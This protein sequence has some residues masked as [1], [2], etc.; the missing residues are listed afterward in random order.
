M[1][2]LLIR[3]F[4]LFVERFECFHCHRGTQLSVSY[5]DWRTPLGSIQYP[6]FNNGLYNVD[7]QGGYPAHDQ[8]LYELTL[9][10]AHRGLFRPP[11]LRNVALTA[12]YMHD[13]SIATLR[14]VVM[15][16]AAGGRLIGSY[17]MVTEALRRRRVTADESDRFVE[18]LLGLELGQAQYERGEA[19]IAGIVQRAGTEV[20]ERLWADEADLPTP[21]EVDAPGLWLARIG[22][23]FE[24]PADLEVP[25]DLSGLDD[26][27]GP[28][29]EA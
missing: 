12:P 15:H 28:P 20:L 19:F 6:F 26:E 13:G 11:S 5:R 23:D 25:D 14:E 22:V 4:Q 24:L 7:G 9:N 1:N 8:G 21:A 2:F 10:P 3:T 17:E 18:R 27:P 16:Y 29:N